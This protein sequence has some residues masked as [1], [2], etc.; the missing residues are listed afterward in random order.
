MPA[1]FTE[2]TLFTT[3]PPEETSVLA[4]SLSESLA[5]YEIN[6]CMS[7]TAWSLFRVDPTLRKLTALEVVGI[8]CLTQKKIVR[9]AFNSPITCIQI[10]R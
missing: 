10:G 7:E 3:L 9:C 8:V 2:I 1:L 6:K 5:S 4:F